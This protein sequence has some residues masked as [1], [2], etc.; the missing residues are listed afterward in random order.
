MHT[1]SSPS[2]AS[3][4]LFFAEQQRRILENFATYDAAKQEQRAYEGWLVG[5]KGLELKEVRK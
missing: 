2:L 4:D 1:F 3:L 5:R